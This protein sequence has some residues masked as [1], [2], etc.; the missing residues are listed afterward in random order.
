[1]S[2]SRRGGLKRFRIVLSSVAAILMILLFCD[3]R[4][5]LPSWT[6]S[7]LPSFQFIPAIIRVIGGMTLIAG[8]TLGVLVILTLLFGRVYCSTLCPLGFYQDLVIRLSRKINRRKRYNYRPSHTT[9][10]YGLLGI[11]GI[12]WVAG[13]MILLDS[14]EPYSMFG[15]MSVAFLQPAVVFL[16]N[17]GARLLITMH[18]YTLHTAAYPWQTAGTF[19][20]TV[21]AALTVGILSYTRGRLF[22][23]LL[24]PAGALLG[25]VSRVSLFRLTIDRTSCNECGACERVCKAECIDSPGKRID[26]AACVGCFN[27][28][29]SCPHGS[30]GYRWYRG[31]QKIAAEK[32]DEGRRS[33]FGI[34]GAPMTALLAPAGVAASL[35]K[36]VKGGPP[37]TPPG[38]WSVAHFSDTCTACQLC[39]TACPSRVLTPTLFEYGLGGLLQPMMNYSSGFCNYECTICGEVCPTGAIRPVPVDIKK[40]IQIGKSTFVREDCVVVA[41]KKDC[42]ACSEHCPTKA[43]HTVPY[44]SGLFIPELNNDLCIGCGA[45]EYACPVQPAKAIFVTASPVH[46]TAKKPVSE[47]QPQPSPVKQDDFPF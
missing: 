46:G 14:L 28:I 9:I 19:L 41:K 38:S 17:L 2:S 26:A 1:V 25:M 18:V 36:P 40:L 20:F 16:N 34:V 44:E 45:C 7:L 35:P 3:I 11:T 42:A 15:R 10:H 4:H 5:L 6:V 21:G 8:I 31:K 30:I 27:C 33:F 24:C 12:A 22:C 23:N 37:V 39:V 47:S 32:Y 13:S 43:V 29:H